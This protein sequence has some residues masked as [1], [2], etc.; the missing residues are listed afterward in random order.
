MH[1]RENT[2]FTSDGGDDQGLKGG[3][4]PSSEILDDPIN[5]FLKL[6][7]NEIPILLG[8]SYLS[9]NTPQGPTYD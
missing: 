7:S 8:V 5:L 2:I 9:T 4:A 6:I 1:V 3:Q